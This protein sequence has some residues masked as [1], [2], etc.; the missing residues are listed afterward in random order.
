MANKAESPGK[1]E[2]KS[3]F[4]EMRAK[5]LS[6]RAI[7][8]DLQLSPQTIS[9]W[10]VELEEEIARMKAVELESLYEEFHLLKEHR[11]KKL[12]NQLLAIEEELSKRELSDVSTEKLMD[13]QLKFFDEVRKEHVEPQYLSDG[14][15]KDLRCKSG[16]KMD[17]EEISIEICRV[18]LRFRA[19]LLDTIRANKELTLLQAMLKAEDQVVLAAKLERLETLL[20]GRK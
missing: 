20:A 4:I 18:L 14:D 12:G 10:H 11:L 2:I 8:K 13:L 3:R 19:G 1:N 16:T 7:A 5:G 6:I 15:L 17:T 9:N